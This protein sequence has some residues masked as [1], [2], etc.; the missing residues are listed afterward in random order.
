[1]ILINCRLWYVNNAESE[2]DGGRQNQ[3]AVPIEIGYMNVIPKC[4]DWGGKYPV[5]EN[6]PETYAA[7]DAYLSEEPLEGLSVALIEI[8]LKSLNLEFF[9]KLFYCQQPLAAP[10]D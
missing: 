8:F 4:V 6:L 1:M 7:I 9:R 5:Y 10:R 3:N 2:E